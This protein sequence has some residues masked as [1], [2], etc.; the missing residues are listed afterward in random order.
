MFSG[1]AADDARR[2]VLGLNLVLS[3]IAA[4]RFPVFTVYFVYRL[5]FALHPQ[6][7]DSGNWVPS[8]D[9]VLV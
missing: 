5:D 7:A 3:A 8:I 1:L 6:R 4:V 9:S 2:G